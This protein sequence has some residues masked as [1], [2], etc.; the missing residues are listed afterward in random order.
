MNPNLYPP[1]SV[2]SLR[3]KRVALAGS[4]GG[5]LRSAAGVLKGAGYLVAQAEDL[6]ALSDLEAGIAP[7]L[8]IFEIDFPPDGAIARG[9]AP[10][11]EAVLAVRLDDGGGP[12]G[13]GRISR[14]RSSRASTTSSS[15]RSRPTSSST[16]RAG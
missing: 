3:E 4:P 2:L 8:V 13:A 5:P 12:R 6:A 11:R 16:R 9:T 7:D 10:A 15:R 14:R 1:S